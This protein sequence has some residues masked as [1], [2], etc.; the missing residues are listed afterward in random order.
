MKPK[1]IAKALRIPTND[2]RRFKRMLAGLERAGKIYRVKGHRFGVPESMELTPG[3]ISITKSGDGF[4]RSDSGGSDLFVP[5]QQLATAMDGDR[6]VAR[7]EARP[8]DR[9]PVARV[10][11]ILE[12]A[13]E[14]I[15]GT[16]H[17]AGRL[18]FVV[19]MDGRLIKDVLIPEGASGEAEDGDI[20]VV[21][22]ESYGEGRLGPVGLVEKVLGALTDPGV[23]VLAVGH[24]FG[25][26][27]DF[28]PSVTEAAAEAARLGMDEP[29][30]NRVDRTDLLVFIIDPADAKD[31]DDALSIIDLG[32]NRFEVGVHIADVSHFV[33]E[34][35]EVDLEAVSRGTS[36]Y[37]VD[38]TV[39]MLPE[40]LSAEVCSLQEGQVRFAVSLFM[41]VDFSGR[42]YSRRYE[43]TM[44]RCT[45]GFAYEDVQEVLDGEGSVGADADA[46]IRRLDDIAR[47]VRD[48]R[49]G[50]GA[51]DFDLPEAKVI[52]DERGIPVDIQ[53]RERLESHRL[54]E[55]F[56][57]L[58]NE[59]VAEDLH[60]KKI[61][62]LYRIHEPPPE[63]K[64]EELRELL[65]RLGHGLSQRKALMPRDLQGLLRAVEGKPEADL[66]SNVVLRSLTKAR[67][68]PDNL[69]HFGLAS[70][71]YLH[72]TS[73]IR[74]YPDLMVHRE[75]IASLV[76][77]EPARDWNPDELRSLADRTSMREQSAVRA[78]RASVAMKKVEF[79]E[80]HL[81]E[82]FDGRISG[83]A[84]FG[85]F[86][87]LD[88]Y[89]VDGL[90]HVNSLRDDF[91][92]LNAEAHALIGERG[93]RRFRLGDR[94]SVQ[95]ARVDKE[96]RQVDFMLIS[97]GTSTN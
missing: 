89:F 60:T 69:G 56:M 62:A 15:V 27:F 94:V 43:R 49:L 40:V 1:E 28:P 93:R 70:E 8:R 65:G 92:R 29:G 67:Y 4:V 74:R 32:D 45:H 95:V 36:V 34:G 35:G 51:L 83:V 59:T 72:F 97:S 18:D 26:S 61:P 30:A 38:R 80:R 42:V 63:G 85:F 10:I 73:P 3:V 54:V 57:I 19:P 22:I 58:A 90:V 7:I 46:A 96:A 84:A 33:E 14:T 2:Y 44:I 71:A 13:R 88:R 20:V 47:A 87:T 11:K 53:R 37:L 48:V 16:F 66:V 86:V 24:G 79:M 64:V 17:G 81:G 52:L 82:D 23:D 31:H 25:V 76:E 91:Y 12:R 75:V 21:R 50:R 78:E 9:N 41:T 77:G 39:P 5:G 68:D 6:V 55:D